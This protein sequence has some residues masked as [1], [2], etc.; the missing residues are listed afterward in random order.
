MTTKDT[1]VITTWN[2]NSD[3]NVSYNGDYSVN[4][5]GDYNV[6]YNGDYSVNYKSEPNGTW[7]L[8]GVTVKDFYCDF[9]AII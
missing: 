2:Y 3:N 9:Y 4:C 6:S 5:N 7:L 8:A 1:H